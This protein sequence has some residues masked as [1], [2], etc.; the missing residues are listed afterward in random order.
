MHEKR[1]G[2]DKDGK[3]SGKRMGKKIS[4]GLEE[5][6]LLG[7]GAHVFLISPATQVPAA[8]PCLKAPVVISI[9]MFA[10]LFIFY[11]G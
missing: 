1:K 2:I 6:D 9:Y 7:G 4:R 8:R 10:P 5:I 11:T 3:E